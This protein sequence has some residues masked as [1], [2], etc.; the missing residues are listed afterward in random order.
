M[1]KLTNLFVTHI[2]K[3]LWTTMYDKW[4]YTPITPA[5]ASVWY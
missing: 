2:L 3:A 1:L 5:S 4:C